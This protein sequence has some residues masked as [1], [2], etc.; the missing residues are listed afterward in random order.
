MSGRSILA[1]APAGHT[2]HEDNEAEVQDREVTRKGQGW[3]RG[4]PSGQVER[5]LDGCISMGMGPWHVWEIP[6]MSLVMALSLLRPASNSA[7]ANQGQ[8]TQVGWYSLFAWVVCKCKMPFAC[9]YHSSAWVPKLTWERWV[10][11]QLTQAPVWTLVFQC[12]WIV[13]SCSHADLL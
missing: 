8:I 6:A 5:G 3:G 4:S 10:S 1:A 13:L 12:L 7:P 9:V 2:F 11:F